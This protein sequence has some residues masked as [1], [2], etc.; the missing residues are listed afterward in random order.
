MEDKVE[1]NAS[2]CTTRGSLTSSLLDESQLTKS[3]HPKLPITCH[4]PFF[5]VTAKP[6]KRNSLQSTSEKPP[7]LKSKPDGYSSFKTSIDVP[8]S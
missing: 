1:W 8:F 3:C 5:P 7:V 6:K 4:G 2:E